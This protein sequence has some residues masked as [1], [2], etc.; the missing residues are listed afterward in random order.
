MD[1]YTRLALMIVAAP[2]ALLV[3]GFALRELRLQAMARR[4]WIQSYGITGRPADLD[5]QIADLR[6]RHEIARGVH[7]KSVIPFPTGREATR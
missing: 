2:P 7:D 5:L 1:D 4:G 6:M 3:T